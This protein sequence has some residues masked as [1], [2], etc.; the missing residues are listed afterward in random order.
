MKIKL[1]LIII[2]NI[3]I[4]INGQNNKV[5]IKSL[6]RDINF[7]DFFGINCEFNLFSSDGVSTQIAFIKALNKVNWIRIGIRFDEL[8]PQ[9]NEPIK[10]ESLDAPMSQI[11]A[12]G[13]NTIVYFTGAPKWASVYTT[14]DG[15][16]S[17]FY[18]P[19]DNN[20]F[21]NVLLE[22]AKR[23]PF[24]KYWQVWD[25]MNDDLYWKSS[26]ADDYSSLFEACVDV[27]KANKLDG[28]LSVGSFSEFGYY[29]PDD[30]NN[31]IDDLVKLDLFKGYTASY[32]PYT[33]YPESTTNTLPI[34]FADQNQSYL[35]VSSAL[36]QVLK[37]AGAPMVF[38]SSWGWSSNNT[39]KGETLQANYI[40]KRLF[41]DIFSNFDKSFIYSLADIPNPSSNTDSS[42]NYY[43]LLTGSLNK[44]DAF[45][46]LEMVFQITG[47]TLTKPENLKSEILGVQ[48]GL[49]FYTFKKTTTNT[50]LVAFYTTNKEQT[51]TLTG[52]T[53]E[54][55]QRLDFGATY[56]N[57]LDIVNGSLTLSVNS[58]MSFL[59]YPIKDDSSDEPSDSISSFKAS[60]FCLILI[61]N[62]IILFIFSL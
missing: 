17:P 2:L 28:L 48:D 22:M 53:G 8:Q 43:G 16:F 37:T 30:T 10:W 13:L 14:D 56:T 33:A 20:V 47:L 12:S 45:K 46:E 23:Y 44:K 50:T 4:F 52:L 49:V 6:N 58:T 26:S 24:V 1:I 29:S 11:K 57:K 21:A 32:Q 31:M 7:L 61:L 54:K 19:K 41:M 25:K 59:E 36:N 62:I 15:E 42:I 55:A 40:V 34:D 3:F 38:S 60:S 18:P 9:E 51:I 35:L 27:F 39:D 5:L